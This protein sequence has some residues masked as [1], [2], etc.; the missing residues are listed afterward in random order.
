MFFPFYFLGPNIVVHLR[1]NPFTML[2]L[3]VDKRHV[4][5]PEKERL[6]DEPR[7]MSAQECQWECNKDPMTLTKPSNEVETLWIGMND[8]Q[9]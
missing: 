1:I 4:I 5:G 6:R 8:L 9:G 3:L 7:A 2:T